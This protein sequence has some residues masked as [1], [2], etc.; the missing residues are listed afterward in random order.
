MTIVAIIGPGAIGGTL[1]A[2]L[3]QDPA[4]TVLVCARTP[5][6][7][8]RLET[9]DGL[10]TANPEVITD[11][12]LAKVVDWVLVCTKTYDADATKPW[13]DRLVGPGTRVAIVQ[14]GVEQVRLFEH[15]VP[16]ER[17]LPVMINLPV[18]RTAPGRFV[19]HRKG[20][21]AVP[22][23]QNG[24]DFCALFARTH[25][26]AGA[27]EDFVSQL[28]VKLTGNSHTIVPT[29]TLGATGPAWSDDLERIVRGV[30]EEC[31]AVGRAEGATIPQ[32]VID[33][34]VAASRNMRAGAVSGSFHAD[35]LAGNRME[36]DA[37]NGVIVRLGEKH[38]IP[39]PMNR[40]L[41]TLL[42]ASGT[43]WIESR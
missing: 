43:P 19:Q 30:V 18:T 22:A 16:A 3:S 33:S 5:F 28:W 14:N 32:S 31:A 29:L 26:E 9:A 27:H 41:V 15:L 36:V 37:R 4:L 21:I 11:P 35:R 39:T 38:G 20:V 7:D 1:A 2:E 8:I 40:V 13:L 10:I 6:E 24:A 25:V 12:L 42:M 23:G 17:L 34:A